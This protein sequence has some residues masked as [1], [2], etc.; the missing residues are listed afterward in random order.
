MLSPGAPVVYSPDLG[1]AALWVIPDL[2]EVPAISRRCV[3]SMH[4]I[5]QAGQHHDTFASEKRLSLLQLRH[6][7]DSSNPIEPQSQQQDVHGGGRYL[8]CY[9][10]HQSRWDT[11]AVAL[12]ASSAID[13]SAADSL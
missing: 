11:L 4:S 13:R 7:S 10:N 9:E 8:E 3:D 12:V 5:R 6:N 1:D 2:D